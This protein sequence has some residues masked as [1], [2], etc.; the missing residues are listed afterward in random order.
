MFKFYIEDF[1]ENDRKFLLVYQ[2]ERKIESF[3]SQFLIFV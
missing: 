1:V 3:A 2:E